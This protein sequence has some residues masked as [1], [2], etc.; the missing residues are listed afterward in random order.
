MKK[1]FAIGCGALV[2]VFIVV[3]IISAI[4]SKPAPSPT[5][6]LPSPSP[7]PSPTLSPTPT[8]PSPTPTPTPVLPP[9]EVELLEAVGR[10]LVE[11]NASGRGTLTAIQLNLTSKS[12]DPLEVTILPGTIF[13]AQAINVQSMV[14]IIEKVILLDPFETTS[15]SVDAACANMRLDIPGDTDK[16]TLRGEAPPEDLV[17][18]L[19]LRKFHEETFRVQQFAI[20]TITDNPKR[21]EYMGIGQFGFGSGPDDEEIQKIK[22]LFEKAGIST[23]KYEALR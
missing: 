9:V 6:T 4:V 1:K 11:V 13:E 10:E 19:N 20:W 21:D 3:A 23:E 17:K 12:D 16:L 14:I 22:T 8:P 2:G 15:T 7:I 18:L 5:P